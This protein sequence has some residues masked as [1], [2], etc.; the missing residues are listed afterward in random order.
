MISSTPFAFL[1]ISVLPTI[2]TLV[3]CFLPKVAPP[4]GS[5]SSTSNRSDLSSKVFLSR[6][7][8][9]TSF[10]VSPCSNVTVPETGAKSFPA[11]AL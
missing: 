3:L 7:G 11:I 6:I 1:I 9:M 10:S 4:V 8:M 2:S 5:N